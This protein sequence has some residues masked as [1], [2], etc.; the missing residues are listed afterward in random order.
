MADKF[1][2]IHSVKFYEFSTTSFNISVVKNLSWNSFY[3]AIQ[4]NAPYVDKNGE[5]KQSCHSVYLT[6]ASVPG[7]LKHLE[8]ALH[9]AQVLAARD[10]GA[11]IF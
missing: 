2:T 11:R 10:K 4:R 7:L 9:F 1:E 3:V 8:P 5:T 6:L